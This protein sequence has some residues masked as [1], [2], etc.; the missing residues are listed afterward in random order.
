[1]IPEL[2]FSQADR[3][4]FIPGINLTALSIESLQIIGEG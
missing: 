2:M 3:K 1:M 4:L